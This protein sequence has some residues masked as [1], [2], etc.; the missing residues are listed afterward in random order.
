LK[1]HNKW[2]QCKYEKCEK[3]TN[4]HCEDECSEMPGPPDNDNCCSPKEDECCHV[5][6]MKVKCT[7]TK[8]C[9]KTYKCCYKLYKFTQYRLYKV[10]SGCGQEFDHYHHHGVC[11]KC[12]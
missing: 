4:S 5:P 7:P 3:D 2:N 8:E 10:C 12:R 6:K 11:P 9:V 1:G